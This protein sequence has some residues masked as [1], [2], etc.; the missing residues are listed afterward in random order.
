M[1]FEEW[2]MGFKIGRRI[3]VARDKEKEERKKIDNSED[4]EKEELAAG[5][6]AGRSALAIKSKVK[7]AWMMRK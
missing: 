2:K 5:L 3:L 6:K 7:A 4:E 1:K